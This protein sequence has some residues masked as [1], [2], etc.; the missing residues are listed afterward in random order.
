VIMVPISRT[1]MS[2]NGMVVTFSLA[3]P[4]DNPRPVAQRQRRSVGDLQAQS[5]HHQ[6]V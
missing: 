2:R 6:V 1:L 3:V 5:L 4:K